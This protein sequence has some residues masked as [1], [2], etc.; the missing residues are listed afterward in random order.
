MPIF[1]L[2]IKGGVRLLEFRSQF[3]FLGFLYA[4]EDGCPGEQMWQDILPI[5]VDPRYEEN[6]YQAGV[7]CCSQDGTQCEAPLNCMFNKKN[8]YSARRYCENQNDANGNS[9]RLC[10]R[11]ELQSGLCCDAGNQCENYEVWT[12]TPLP[13]GNICS[14]CQYS[15]CQNEGGYFING[16]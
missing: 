14:H 16:V 1:S 9:M 3:V 10:T 8:Q 13:P 15:I 5:G 7:L 2:F 12:S 11:R 4:V 6:V